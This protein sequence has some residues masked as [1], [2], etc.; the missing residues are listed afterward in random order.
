[1]SKP[2]ANQL[3]IGLFI[4][5]IIGGFSWWFL[6]HFEQEAYELRSEMSPDAKRNPLLAAE[7][8]L[9]RL[10]QLAESR[11][12]R[13]SLIHPPAQG[14]VL[15]VKDLGAPLPQERVDALLAWVAQGGQLIAAPGRLQD[16]ELNR[17]L[18]DRFGVEVVRGWDLDT[19]SGRREAVMEKATTSILMPYD[20][21]EPLEIAFDA[22]AWFQ[23]DASDAYW[24]SPAGEAPHL[25]IFP[26]GRGF[27]TFLS[28]SDFFDNQRIGDYDHAPFLAELC[29]G[30]ERVWLLYSSQMPSLAG[31]VWRWAPYLVVSL[32]LVGILSVWRMS[33]GS[34][35]RILA[36]Q[37]QRRD[38][39][40]HLQAA[41]EFNWRIDP[42]ASLLQQARR[43]VEKRWL[44]SHPQL[45]RLDTDARCEWLSERTGMTSEAIE[46]ALY[47]AQPDGGQLVKIT[48]HLQRLLAALHPHNTKR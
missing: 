24:Q 40:E 22:D 10:G 21:D 42:S 20:T 8:L 36:G 1:M 46:L 17:P 39:L 48:A 19:L 18:L 38:L 41:A 3:A 9:N 26:W 7:R 43:Q 44:L 29:A 2:N 11:S 23:V 13:Q 35:P 25:L 31:L 32:A 16:D 4:L 6:E 28:D 34:G 27:V 37:P 12:G 30:P 47:K 15:L 45:H 33:R 14:G 5:L